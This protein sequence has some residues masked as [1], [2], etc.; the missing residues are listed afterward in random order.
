MR[1]CEEQSGEMEERVEQ[2][3]RNHEPAPY[4][5]P[6]PGVGMGIAPAF[7]ACA[8]DGSR[9]SKPP[10]A[11]NCAGLMPRV[12]CSWDTD[13]YGHVTKAG[14]RPLGAVVL[15]MSRPLLR[16]KFHELNGR[17]GKTKSAAAGVPAVDTGNAAGVL[18]GHEPR[19]ACEAAAPL[20]DYI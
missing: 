9:F 5:L 20:Q 14:C 2:K 10:E 18:R 1:L 17:M 12:D 8:G 6:V 19:G 11:A 15:R 3:V 7:L 13:R 16:A 4:V